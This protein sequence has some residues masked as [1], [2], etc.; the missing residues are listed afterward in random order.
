MPVENISYGDKY[1]DEKYEYRNVTLPAELAKLVPR[2]HLMTETEWRNM[3]VQQSPGRTERVRL[4]I[5]SIDQFQAGFTTC[6]T[7]RS[8]RFCYSEDREVNKTVKSKTK[9]G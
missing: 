6:F 4:L 8:R 5:N 7:L 3:G 1:Q 9:T 2:N